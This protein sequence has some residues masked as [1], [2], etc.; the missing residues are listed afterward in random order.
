VLGWQFSR[1]AGRPGERTVT[2]VE[3]CRLFVVRRSG[4]GRVVALDQVY[5]RP[6]GSVVQHSLRRGE[7]GW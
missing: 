1:R 3:E 5:V 4:V 6:Q 7:V 2:M